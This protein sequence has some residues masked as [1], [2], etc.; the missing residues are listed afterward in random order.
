MTTSTP[1]LE[2][3]N[4]GLIEL[5]DLLAEQYEK[6]RDIIQYAKSIRAEGGRLHIAG[7]PEHLLSLEG[8]TTVHAEGVYNPTRV[9][10]EGIATKLEI[11]LAYVRKMRTEHPALWDAN[12]NGWLERDGGR[13]FLV[14]TFPGVD[15]EPGIARAFL[16]HKYQIIDNYDVLSA[17]LMGVRA[18]G[19]EVDIMG[20]DLTERRMHVRA[21]ARNLDI[22]APEL[23]ANYKAPSGDRG[24]DNPMVG[25]GFRL[26]NGELGGGAYTISPYVVIRVCT[27]G[28]TLPSFTE[29][30]V[31]LSGGKNVGT[32]QWSRDTNRKHLD[33][34][35]SRTSD[36]VRQFL[37]PEVLREFID[38]ITEQAA[39]KITDPEA[40]ITTVCKTLKFSDEQR[41]DIFAHFIGGGDVTAGGV[42]QA[43]TS[44]A[45]IQPDGDAAAEMDARA[46]EALALAAKS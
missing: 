2:I 19:V 20:T 15:G 5:R 6:R 45:Q 33:L 11:P 24:S 25:L 16:S 22:A 1:A 10:D 14:R 40:V 12:V 32:I 46:L 23:L 26:A 28:M 37:R 43:V 36:A 4:G 31:H 13:K 9:C 18:A 29:R 27:N 42:M 44:V 8:V 3:R 39:V 7:E 34:I 30:V 17:A 41:K 35:T 21:V 38:G